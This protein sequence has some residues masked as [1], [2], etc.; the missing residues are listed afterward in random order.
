MNVYVMDESLKRVG[1][2]DSY[3]SII[4]TRRYYEAGDFELFLDATQENIDLCKKNR[5]LYREGDYEDGVFKSV[6][7]IR[8][9]QLNTSIDDG[10]TLLLQGPDL[11]S[12][13][14]RRIIWNQTILSGTLEANIR[15]VIS[16]NIINPSIAARKIN[17]FILG[18]QMG[19]TPT[20]QIQS[21]GDAIDT[22]LTE[23]ITPYEIGYDVQIRDGQFVFLLYKGLDRSYEQSANPYVIFSPDFEN[24][25]ASDYVESQIDTK[26]FA[27]VAGE[28]EGSA[29][30]VTTVGNNS[31]SGLDRIELYV[32]ARDISKTTDS[33]TLTPAQYVAQLQTRGREKLAEFQDVQVFEGEVEAETNFIYGVDYFLGDKVQVVNEY[34]IGAA[35]RIVGIIDAEDTAGRTVVPTFSTGGQ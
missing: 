6:M 20:V 10:D 9:V 1:V 31:L 16:S 32:D 35:A 26:N 4:W 33:G 12:I 34:G 13:V 25:L 17:N 22:W 8:Y 23:Q 11:K 14:G 3:R 2:I 27:L 15:S 30:T 24:L 18:D 21:T 19:G 28:G 5:F 7:I 29:R